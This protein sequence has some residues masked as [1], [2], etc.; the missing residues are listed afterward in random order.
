MTKL[1]K[2]KTKANS[3]LDTRGPEPVP[4]S[5]LQMFLLSDKPGPQPLFLLRQNNSDH[6]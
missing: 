1:R 3:D 2:G 6:S 5:R 4:T